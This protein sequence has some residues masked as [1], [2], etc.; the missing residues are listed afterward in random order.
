MLTTT[1]IKMIKEIKDLNKWKNISYSWTGRL[2]I[3]NMSIFPKLL[4]RFNIT[5]NQNCNKI[6][7]HR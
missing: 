4:F 1:K 7:C 5:T 3:V 2:T 6:F